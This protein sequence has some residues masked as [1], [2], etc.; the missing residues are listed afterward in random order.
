MILLDVRQ[1]VKKAKE[2]TC[3]KTH[4]C[5]GRRKEKRGGASGGAERDEQ[6]EP[7]H[8]RL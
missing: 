5:M 4:V 2:N 3:A 1:R 7:R 6:E 8:S